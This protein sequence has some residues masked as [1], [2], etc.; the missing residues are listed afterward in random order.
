MLH[1]LSKA[2]S[3]L[4]L[5]GALP[6]GAGDRIA[7]PVDASRTVVLQGN[8]H[9]LAQARFDRGPVD[10]ATPVS[11]ATLHLQPAAGLAEFLAD[12]QNPLSANYHRWLTPEQFGERFGLSANDLA[13]IADWLR[14]EGLQ[15][16]DVAR[17][18]HWIT[19]SGTAEQ[20]GRAFHTE[21]HRYLVDGKWH[22]ANAT[23]PS[24]P[25][26]LAEVVAGIRGL[27]DFRL[28]SQ[29]KV[30]PP[31]A[32]SGTTTGRAL[33]P[34]DFA[35]IYD[36]QKLYAAGIDGTGQ[37]IAILG[38]S[39]IHL[40]D[41]QAFR[42][43]F[44]LPAN[45]PQ[46]MLF[47]PDPG[48]DS[49]DLSEAT[50]D[51][52]WSGAVARNAAILYVYS[53]D[54]MTSA[55]YAVDQNL[56][57][58]MSLSY[59]G[60]ESYNSIAARAVAQQGNAQGITWFAASGDQ[61]AVACDR[62][63]A[64]PQA[65][66]GPT[67]VYPASIP[68]ITAV[69]GTEFTDT[70]SAFWAMGNDASSASALSY[71]PEKAWNDFASSPSV[72][73]FATGGGASILFTKPSWQA[74]PGV[75]NDNARDLPDVSLPSSGTVP[76]LGILNGSPVG[77]SGTSA[78]SPSFAGLLA[79]VNQHVGGNGLG[80]INPALY[81]LAQATRDVFHDITV[82]DNKAACEQGSAGCVNGLVGFHAGTGY[83]M[84][85][86]LG[87]VDGY[88]LAMEWTGAT[89]TSTSLRVTPNAPLNLSDT[90]QLSA[91]V[92]GSGIAPTGMVTFLNNDIAVGSA[93]LT[94][95][96]GGAA[97]AGISVGAIQIASGYG[98]V[99]ALY[100]GDSVYNGSESSARIVL[101]LPAGAALAVPFV[102]PNPVYESAA[103]GNWLFTAGVAERGGVA[104][105]ITAFSIDGN[106]DLSLFGANPKLGA[107]STISLAMQSSGFTAPRNRVV[108]FSG[109]DA[110]GNKWTQQLTVPFLAPLGTQIAP[111]ISLTSP[112]TTVQQNPQADP[113]CQ[114][115]LPLVVQELGGYPVSLTSFA[116]SIS[117]L[118][119]QIQ[120]VFGTT[121]LAPYGMLSGT[122][123]FSGTTPPA[124]KTVQIQGTSS[125]ATAVSSTLSPSFTGASLAPATMSAGVTSVA[126]ASPAGSTRSPVPL[127]FAGGTPQ[128]T[129]SV[130]P[131]N[132][133][134]TWLTVTPISGSGP[135]N[136]N[137]QASAAGLS[138]GVY[139]AVVSIQA[140]DAV[141]QAIDLP[142]TFVVGGSAS[143]QITGLENAFSLQSACAPGMMLSVYGT[144]LAN[145]TAQAL[146]LPLPLTLGGVSAAVN[147]FS[148]PLYSVSPGQIN[149]Q[150]PYEA[151]AGQAV[152]A[153]DNNGQIASFP[154]T[155][156]PAAPGVLGT[157]YDN[158]TGAPVA[159]AQAGGPEVLLLFVTGEGDVTPTLGTGATPMPTI[160]NPANLPHSR[161]PLTLT[162]G[163][164]AVTSSHGLLFNGIPSGLAGA[165]QI[166]FQIPASVPA[167][168]QPIVVT[169]GGVPAPAIFLNVTASAAQ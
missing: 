70:G 116:T 32:E 48:S 157:V 58:V 110:S 168:K 96:P 56:A 57:P 79:L 94:V 5:A 35:T 36:L 147:G 109:T 29:A 23:R 11:Y 13:K 45:N 106:N 67:V 122:V 136:V 100:G 161:L 149:L 10:P 17:G 54:V 66:L 162:I 18:R 52:E 75:P 24:V 85:T 119:S 105:S 68:E 38:Q 167:G 80:N 7:V 140:M 160:T 49:T 76:Y 63:D 93:P 55:Q 126:L 83:D 115:A 89:S 51:L 61:G 74:G 65:T 69:G 120:T 117:L 64:T 3:L 163:G 37:T 33:A 73:F 155:T 62:S 145:S 28:E 128:W 60:C 131:A 44:N 144:Q 8:I 90:V 165:T 41:I 95:L 30:V 151:G 84:T 124:V 134:S 92:T 20:A 125:L 135:G 169:V 12:Q 139:H 71:V 19:F 4:L 112:V 26:A 123:C 99:T 153:I 146:T 34:D 152:L 150:V 27:D 53:A 81:R 15:I 86:G 108:S 78:S 82:G 166:D 6:A 88:N 46:V 129:A 43:Q 39:G 21:I 22:F 77:Y 31:G 102:D 9:P 164:V 47:G 121:R 98:V 143:T 111:G 40:S 14:A 50:L 133:T 156:A 141:P 97:T 159:T 16:H 107:G 118:T 148:A 2:A 137:I 132:R 138:P 25:A 59:G 104:S 113:S 101:N 142:V 87:S 154:F 72:A 1:Q 91:T 103:Y 114:W 42:A 158:S 130:S 127:N